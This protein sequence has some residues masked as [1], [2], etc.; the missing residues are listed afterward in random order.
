MLV[1][2]GRRG[3]AG[4]ECGG[5]RRFRDPRLD[6]RPNVFRNARPATSRDRAG[7]EQFGTDVNRRLP[8][9]RALHGFFG[10]YNRG[11]RTVTSRRSAPR[12]VLLGLGRRRRLQQ[13]WR[14]AF[15]GRTTAFR[16]FRLRAGETR[17]VRLDFHTATSIR[18]LQDGSSRIVASRPLPDPRRHPHRQVPFD[19]VSSG[20][21]TPASATTP[22]NRKGAGHVLGV[23]S[24]WPVQRG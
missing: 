20:I 14:P 3:L 6:G 11:P 16:P 4:G 15:E 9:G 24:G 10:L 5:T 19:Q 2:T 7:P 12:V 21:Q 8:G 23:V 17:Y 22:L 13:N 1:V 18:P